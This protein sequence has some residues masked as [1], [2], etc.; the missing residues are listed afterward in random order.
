[1]EKSLQKNFVQEEYRS[2]YEGRTD[3]KQICIIQNLLFSYL[4]SSLYLLL[5]L[6]IPTPS[7]FSL[8]FEKEKKSHKI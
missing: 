4:Y 2:S 5:P 8:L 6:L 1:M 7:I 3:K